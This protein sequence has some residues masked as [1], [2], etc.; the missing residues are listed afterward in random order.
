MRLISSY[1]STVDG[2]TLH[3][4]SRM[5]VSVIREKLQNCCPAC[6]GHLHSKRSSGN[7]IMHAEALP[8]PQT[9][10][11]SKDKTSC[12]AGHKKRPPRCTCMKPNA[13]GFQA[14]VSPLSSNKHLPG[15]SSPFLYRATGWGPA[16]PGGGFPAPGRPGRGGWPM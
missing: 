12:L 9:C 14:T 16:G 7:H 11:T 1:Y 6:R 15:H 13:I 4:P 3:Q 2:N 10:S 5:L 8:P